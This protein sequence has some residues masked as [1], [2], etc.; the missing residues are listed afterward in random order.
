LFE[1]NPTAAAPT[2]RRLLDRIVV[3]PDDPTATGNLTRLRAIAGP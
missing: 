3:V 1:T 2:A